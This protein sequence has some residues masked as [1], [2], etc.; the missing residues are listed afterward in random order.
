LKYTGQGAGIEE[1]I[2]DRKYR[3]ETLHIE[4]PHIMCTSHIFTIIKQIIVR[5]EGL[6]ARIRKR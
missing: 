2:N 1:T 4:E 3:E 6:A 5:W